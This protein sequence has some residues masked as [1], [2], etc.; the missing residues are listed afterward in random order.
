VNH[1]V[2]HAWLSSINP[3]WSTN[4]EAAVMSDPD[5]D[6]F[7]TWQEYWSGTDPQN[8]NSFLRIDSV[9]LTGSSATLQW[10]HASISDSIPAITI[11][12]RTNLASGSW[13]PVGQK[14][15]VNG[16]NI[17]VGS[18]ASTQIFYRLAVT[19]AP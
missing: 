6:G 8:S 9:S 15:P 2:P 1:A 14:T 17:W 18:S 12:T 7:T 4:Y 19:N 16:T 3:S 5:S 11:L 10:R 13:I